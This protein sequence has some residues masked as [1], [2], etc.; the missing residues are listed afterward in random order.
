[1]P[2]Y[3]YFYSF[4]FIAPC[5][6]DAFNNYNYIFNAPPTQ[7]EITVRYVQTVL[8]L[9]VVPISPQFLLTIVRLKEATECSSCMIKVFKK[10]QTVSYLSSICFL[11]EQ[12]GNRSSMARRAMSTFLCKLPAEAGDLQTKLSAYRLSGSIT[13]PYVRNYPSPK[14][15]HN[16][17]Q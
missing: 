4:T 17:L 7:A 14:A 13:A 9:C 8:Y 16:K 15:V 12:S 1:M 11:R 6:T 5:N 2:L 3:F 10:L